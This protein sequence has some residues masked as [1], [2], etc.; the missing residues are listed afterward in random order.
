MRAR[1][2]PEILFPKKAKYDWGYYEPL[3]KEIERYS[4][5][6]PENKQETS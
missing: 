5:F 1:G 2:L 3:R 6:G 4:Y